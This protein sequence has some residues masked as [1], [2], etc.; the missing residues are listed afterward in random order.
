MKDAR[1][2]IPALALLAKVVDLL[3]QTIPSKAGRS[4]SGSL[5]TH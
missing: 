1:F 4:G 2:T 3:N 5:S